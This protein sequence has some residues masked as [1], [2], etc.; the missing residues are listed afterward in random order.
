MMIPI[1]KI[2]PGIRAQR[3]LISLS[4]GEQAINCSQ[5]DDVV[6]LQLVDDVGKKLLPEPAVSIGHIRHIQQRK[7]QYHGQTKKYI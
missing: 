3:G 7:I 5:S 6:S 2:Q 1:A 4:S